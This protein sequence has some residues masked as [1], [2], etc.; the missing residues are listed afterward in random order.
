[1]LQLILPNISFYG[2][3]SGILTG[4]LQSSG[5]LNCLL[6]TDEH[7]LQNM[8][9]WPVLNVL[10]RCP[11]F[12]PATVEAAALGGY[13]LPLVQTVT[14]AADEIDRFTTQTFNRFRRHLYHQTT[15]TEELSD[16]DWNGL[17]AGEVPTQEFV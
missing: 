13:R 9:E 17:S 6:I 12:V 16:D 4:F 2:H 7:R 3:L 11:A 14:R 1:M 10:T 8:E 5:L 15:S